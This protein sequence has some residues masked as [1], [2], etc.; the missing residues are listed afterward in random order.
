MPTLDAASQS[1]GLQGDHG[2]TLRA[3]HRTRAFDQLETEASH[4]TS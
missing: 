4:E 1:M 2:A 3:I